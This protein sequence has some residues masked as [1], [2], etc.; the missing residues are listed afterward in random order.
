MQLRVLGYPVIVLDQWLP[1]KT[2]KSIKQELEYLE[3]YLETPAQTNSAVDETG[4]PL[5][6]NSAIWLDRVYQNRQYSRTL[7]ALDQLYTPEF[8][9]ELELQDRFW[10]NLSTSMCDSSLLQ[11]W[12]IGNHYPKH[13]DKSALTAIYT[14]SRSDDCVGSN[15]Y[16]ED[17]TITTNANQLIL[18]PGFLQHQTLPTERGV[19]WSVNR[20]IG[21]LNYGP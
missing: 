5:R 2:V 17:Q 14:V 9:H 7:Q 21:H 20:F 15:I 10:T 11:R 13:V 8:M 18:M 6:E 1:H 3:P 12:S 19:R 16:I 4:K